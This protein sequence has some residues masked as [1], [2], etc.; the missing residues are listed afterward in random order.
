MYANT[1]EREH[2]H[3]KV[4]NIEN[5]ILEPPDRQGGNHDDPEARQSN[6]TE[7]LLV[8]HDEPGILD[9]SCP[10]NALKGGMKSSAKGS[11]VAAS[12]MELVETLV[13]ICCQQSQR[14]IL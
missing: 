13:R 10:S 8:I 3:Y 7:F 6:H 14:G 5:L 11:R 1:D 12:L 2:N 9:S 4:D